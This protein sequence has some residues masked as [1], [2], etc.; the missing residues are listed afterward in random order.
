[1]AIVFNEKQKVFYLHSKNSSY[2]FGI[3]KNKVLVH[4][5]WGNKINDIGDVE[6]MLWKGGVTL[7]ATDIRLDGEYSTDKLMTEY[8]TYGNTD[9]RSPAFHAKYENGSRT[10][11][12]DY[13]GYKITK[14]KPALQ[15]LPAVYAEN[16]SEADTLE[17]ELKDDLTGMSVFLSYT[18]FN[19]IDAIIRSTR[20]VNNGSENITLSRV[21]S[22]SVDFEDNEFDM[23]HL[24][25][26]WTRE[27][28]VQRIPLLHGTQTVDSK[29]GASSAQHNPFVALLRKDA[30]EDKGEVYGMNFVYSGNFIAGA[31]V[32]QFFTT[33]MFMGINP[34]DFGWNL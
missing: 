30:T 16:D 28:H 14:G 20:V 22:A 31:E 19:E 23:L 8:P 33:R 18:V 13:I 11:Q 6:R 21:L 3:L 17:V 29:R 24:R 34:F 4:L 32:D 10:T 12:L 26:A 2:I 15:G 5:H 1:M 25:G 9:L 7:S 27:R